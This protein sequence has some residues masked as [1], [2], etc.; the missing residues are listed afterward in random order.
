MQRLAAGGVVPQRPAGPGHIP[1]VPRAPGPQVRRRVAQIV[2][3]A[4]AL[5]QQSGVRL[6]R[7]SL[8]A[9]GLA[10]QI[11]IIVV[12]P[13]RLP[14]IGGEQLRHEVCHGG[15]V[16]D[17]VAGVK[18]QVYMLR[19]RIDGAA[20]QQLVIQVIGADQLLQHL[21]RVFLHPADL[22]ADDPAR[23]IAQHRLPLLAVGQ[24]RAEQ[25][26]VGEHRL[27]RRFQPLR[28][29]RLSGE[30]EG[31]GIARLRL[32]GGVEY[33]V[34]EI[35][36]VRGQA[37]VPR[38]RRPVPFVQ[39]H[40]VL[41]PKPPGDL[42]GR[43]P[44]VD[45]L[46]VHLQRPQLRRGQRRGQGVPAQLKEVVVGAHLFQVQHLLIAPADGRLLRALRRRVGPEAGVHVRLRQGEA[47]HLAVAVERH[48]AKPH[49]KGRDHVMGQGPAEG[50]ADLVLRKLRVRAVVGAEE[51][52]LPL[53]AKV[54]HRRVPDPGDPAQAGLDLP[55][56]HPVAV[57][58]HHGVEPPGHQD[59]PVRQ[60][61]PHVA[62][63]EDAAFEHLLR[64][65]RQV[66]IAP[67][68]GVVETDLALLPD[69]D[70]P[71]LFVQE[72]DMNVRE[73]R[74]ADGS[75][76]IAPVDHKLGHMEARL[77][78]TVVVDEADALKEDAVGG[79]AAGHQGFQAGGHAVRHHP[80]HRGGEEGQVHPVFTELFVHPHRVPG[81]VHGEEHHVHPGIQGVEPDLH[82]GDEVDGRGQG[83][84]GLLVG[85]VPG[86][87]LKGG[88][89]QLDLAVLLQHALGLAGA[90][91]GVDG[92]AGVM[93]LRLPVALQGL[94]HQDLRPG[95]L[96]DLQAA[97]AVLP[98][99]LDPFRRVAVL[100]HGEGG[101]GLPHTQH[102]D[103]GPGV[104]GQADQHKVLPA[105]AFPRKI[106]VH[107]GGQ[108]VH[109]S[110][111]EAALRLLLR[112]EDGR[113]LPGRQRRP[114]FAHIG[115]RLE[116][117]QIHR[118][119]LQNMGFLVFQCS[120]APCRLSRAILSFSELS[121][122]AG[123]PTGDMG[124]PA[125][126]L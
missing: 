43:F 59:V 83:D 8:A 28:L 66:H 31:E 26:V 77:A 32:S 33:R 49:K 122:K 97:A 71:S 99:R 35:G 25:R 14:P 12:L 22:R 95:V 67:E 98:D 34:I 73:H 78:H 65:L 92:K 56:L 80:Q 111:G 91:G 123:R 115:D 30:A 13:Q 105:D 11:V 38:Q 79:L 87:C 29:H 100:H 27:Q 102:G 6:Q 37:L 106:A 75:H 101:P 44:G 113:R 96:V 118:Q 63:V 82:R 15:P 108:L 90:A 110:P 120:T 74:L 62:G 10:L 51:N 69:G 46:V 68:K 125:L 60:A 45:I 20:V 2:L 112:Q 40:A 116:K 5:H 94:R 84:A 88:L 86:L 16:A 76:V 1:P 17:Q 124:R 117:I 104:P 18:V 55:R 52:L 119:R 121:K 42:P 19:R 48:A 114:T 21:R 50:R 81:G 64:L 109:L 72:E 41:F 3:P 4:E 39:V 126:Y 70:L 89:V 85:Q 47:V 57:D 7:Q 24:H 103:K 93:L 9:V 36:L 107:P 53:V 58:L 54:L 61:H 23:H